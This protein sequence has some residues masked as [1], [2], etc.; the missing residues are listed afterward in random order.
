[1]RSR[2]R[3]ANYPATLRTATR[4]SCPIRL[5]DKLW[6][7]VLLADLLWEK[8]TARWLKKYDLL[9][10][11]IGRLTSIKGACLGLPL[12][13]PPLHLC[14]TQSL[15]PLASPPFQA[16]WD[17]DQHQLS[18]L[19]VQVLGSAIQSRPCLDSFSK[20]QTMFGFML[21]IVSSN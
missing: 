12:R 2:V 15:W 10:K 9:A 5:A 21:L 3:V 16:D 19:A 11:R 13:S 20:G 17:V 6:L 7:K 8:N 14:S 1:M 18:A 4:V